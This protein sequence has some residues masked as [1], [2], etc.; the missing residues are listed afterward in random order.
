[1]LTKRGVRKRDLLRGSRDAERVRQR[2]ELGATR[3]P[4]FVDI[5]QVASSDGEEFSMHGRAHFLWA[6]SENQ[7]PNLFVIVRRAP[8][9]REEVRAEANQTGRH[10]GTVDRRVL[11]RLAHT[12]ARTV[13]VQAVQAARIPRVRGVPREAH[14]PV[15]LRERTV[16]PQ[17]SADAS[18][19][20][21]VSGEVER[22]LGQHDA[23]H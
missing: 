16:V 20:R 6:V 7:Q 10:C 13:S 19:E 11:S 14:V 3:A 9:A 2:H 22:D 18:C 21:V 1:M 15:R 5:N 8:E 12:Q 23:L 17:A 4:P